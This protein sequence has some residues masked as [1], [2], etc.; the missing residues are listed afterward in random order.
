[1]ISLLTYAQTSLV[2]A[3][4]QGCTKIFWAG[5][6]GTTTKVW[7]PRGG[8]RIGSREGRQSMAEEVVEEREMRE[9]RVRPIVAS[10]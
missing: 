9:V 10:S 5:D 7:L 3:Q 2:Q 4:M 6:T 1:M 8:E